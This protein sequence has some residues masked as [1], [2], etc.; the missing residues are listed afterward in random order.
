MTARRSSDAAG[1]RANRGHFG[2][3]GTYTSLVL[4]RHLNAGLSVSRFAGCEATA[5]ARAV[6]AH[7]R[8]ERACPAGTTA[9]CAVR[10]ARITSLVQNASPCYIVVNIKRQRRGRVPA[11]CPVSEPGTVRARQETRRRISPLSRGPNEVAPT[12]LSSRLRRRLA[13]LSNRR[14]RPARPV[15]DEGMR[16]C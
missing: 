14:H 1:T 8:R 9:L 6:E 3:A 13:P 12:R 2:S 4:T 11:E 15:P 7:S 10:S 5:M 16:R